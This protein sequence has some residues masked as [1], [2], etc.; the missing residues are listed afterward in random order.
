MRLLGLIFSLCE[1]KEF[2]KMMAEASSGLKTAKELFVRR[3][4][5]LADGDDIPLTSYL[6]GG[7]S[8]GDMR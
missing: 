4:H 5:V 8:A 3:V 2:H 6:R 1:M 7:S